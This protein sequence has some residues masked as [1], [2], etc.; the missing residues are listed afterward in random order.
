MLA[1]RVV[2]EVSCRAFS[3][4]TAAE[5]RGLLDLGALLGGLPLSRAEL[6]DPRSRV[7]WDL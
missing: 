2:T 1:L 3:Y 7:S 5:A 4:F 6:E